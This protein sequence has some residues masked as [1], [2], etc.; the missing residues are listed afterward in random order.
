MSNKQQTS[1]K[2]ITIMLASGKSIVLTDDITDDTYKKL[3]KEIESVVNNESADSDKSLEFKTATDSILVHHKH[4]SLLGLKRKT[5]HNPDLYKYEI[6]LHLDNSKTIVFS[7]KEVD[8]N[9]SKYEKI[10][11][12]SMKSFDPPKFL[13]LSSTD[14]T[15][16]VNTNKL[17][18]S[19]IR[20]R[21]INH[22]GGTL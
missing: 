4:V 19:V 3:E 13:I 1:K 18:A 14:E 21:N 12:Y 7:N 17:Y 10:I 2:Q 6:V 20:Q 9:V 11:D 16:F 22:R 8:D 5:D 15:L